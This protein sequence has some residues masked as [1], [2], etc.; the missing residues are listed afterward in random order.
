[1][2]KWGNIEQTK[3]LIDHERWALIDQAPKWAEERGDLDSVYRVDLDG[4]FCC[5]C[6][7][8][9]SGWRVVAVAPLVDCVGQF[10]LSVVG[11][12]VFYGAPWPK[13]WRT[14]NRATAKPA[15]EP[16][17]GE[18]RGLE[19]GSFIVGSNPKA[20]ITLA[21]VVTVD[22]DGVPVTIRTFASLEPFPIAEEPLN[23]RSVLKWPDGVAVEWL[24]GRQT[25]SSFRWFSILAGNAQKRHDKLKD[26]ALRKNKRK[27]LQEEAKE[28]T[29]VFELEVKQAAARGAARAA[30]AAAYVPGA[31]SVAVPD[32]WCDLAAQFRE[33]WQELKDLFD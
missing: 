29:P 25:Y 15:Y 12:V 20:E 24:K 33:G 30:G 5:W 14:R 21:L 31:Q 4:E 28:A 23:W 13:S 9:A 32:A 17:R 22:G 19:P 6:A 26:P 2:S 7:H 16:S 27:R 1:M 18:L 8:Y 3:A 11:R 10:A